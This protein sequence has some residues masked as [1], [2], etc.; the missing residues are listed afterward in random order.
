[1]SWGWEIPGRHLQGVRKRMGQKGACGVLGVGG[2]GQW[3]QA[4]CGASVGRMWGGIGCTGAVAGTPSGVGGCVGLRG[5]IWVGEGWGA[6]GGAAEGPRAGSGLGGGRGHRGRGGPAPQRDP[7]PGTGVFPPPPPGV[8]PTA[9]T[10][11]KRWVQPRGVGVPLP[12]PTPHGHSS[13]AGRPS[14]GGG[15][16]RV[17]IWVRL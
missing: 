4:G 13:S 17:G 12:P 2:W 7:N 15:S 14:L 6:L 1:M 10:E 8:V 9:A 11:G 5:R 16:S 3:C